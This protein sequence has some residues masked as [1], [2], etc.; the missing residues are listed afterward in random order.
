[1]NKYFIYGNSF[2]RSG[3]INAHIF[4]GIWKD[5][6]KNKLT[7]VRANPDLFGTLSKFS[8]EAPHTNRSTSDVS[9]SQATLNV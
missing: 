5:M 3:L 8:F 1:M 7:V 2:L 9:P 4:R 6:F